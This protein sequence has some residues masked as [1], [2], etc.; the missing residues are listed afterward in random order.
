M[1]ESLQK[2][3]RKDQAR[4]VKVK[5]EEGKALEWG[6]WGSGERFGGRGL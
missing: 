2:E 6:G 5:D 1:S 3:V 4:K